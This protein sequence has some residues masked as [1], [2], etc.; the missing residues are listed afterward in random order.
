L[1]LSFFL[2]FM[3][4][5]YFFIFLLFEGHPCL[6]FWLIGSA[7]IGNFLFLSVTSALRGK[8]YF[9][10]WSRSKA[11]VSRL[12]PDCLHVSDRASRAPSLSI[13][14][15]I[16]ILIVVIVSLTKKLIFGCTG[17]KFSDL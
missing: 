12:L 9:P 1:F 2:V 15:C 3:L 4:F 5:L 14:P 11:D 7:F 10:S 16:M 8:F 13:E 17:G 6:F